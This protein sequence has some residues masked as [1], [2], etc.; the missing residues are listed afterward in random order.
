MRQLGLL[1]WSG[2]GLES[3]AKVRPPCRAPFSAGTAELTGLRV[4]A[5]V[6]GVEWSVAE[7]GKSHSL[8]QL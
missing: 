4:S 3:A 6:C 1:G 7:L 5:L 2:G 8:A